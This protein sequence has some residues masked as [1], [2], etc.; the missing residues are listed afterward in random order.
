MSND[1]V[2]CFDEELVEYDK[3]L[4]VTER[5]ILFP[6]LRLFFLPDYSNQGEYREAH[7]G[8][9]SL[10]KH[11]IIDINQLLTKNH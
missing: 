2:Q 10:K 1:L 11:F 4:I 9:P 7:L 3:H 5:H 6:F 8:K